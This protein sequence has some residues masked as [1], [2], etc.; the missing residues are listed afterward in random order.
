MKLKVI[1]PVTIIVMTGVVISLSVCAPEL[2]AKNR[3][4][5]NF[6]N[7]ELLNTLAVIVTITIAS[8]ATI[9]IW[10]NELEEKHEKRVF[11]GARRDINNSAMW[12]VGLFAATVLLLI[13]RAFFT[14]DMALS[15]FNG[16]GL[17]FLFVTLF[18]LI[19]I[20]GVVRALTPKD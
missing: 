13:F 15:L 16:A 19:D 18:V 12:L 10:F 9:H 8:I 20:L 3:F 2:L 17:I 11:G 7:H 4:L 5:M 1:A 6:I 14:S